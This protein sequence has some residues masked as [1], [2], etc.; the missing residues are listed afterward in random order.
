M[1][2]PNFQQT[3]DAIVTSE[4]LH[5]EE[6]T[7]KAA[8]F[9]AKNQKDK[10]TPLVWATVN[11]FLDKI[12][13]HLLCEEDY[14]NPDSY[15]WNLIHYALA[16]ENLGQIP[17]SLITKN[18]LTTPCATD[19]NTPLHYGALFSLMKHLISFC[20]KGAVQEE[21]LLLKNKKGQN[22]LE[23]AIQTNQLHYL[24]SN[25]LSLKVLLSLLA[26]P[27]VT[28]TIHPE[29]LAWIQIE[30]KTQKNAALKSSFQAL[31]SFSS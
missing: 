23:C 6:A 4:F 17:L 15:G 16:H 28:R 11:G 19:K 18:R 3:R 25:T 27:T 22:V 2:P 31:T 8:L 12:P 5:W 7:Q 20:P 13:A 30:K 26:N 29:D 9:C 1:A 14:T 24:P 21:G 10:D